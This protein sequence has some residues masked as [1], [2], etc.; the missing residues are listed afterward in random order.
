MSKRLKLNLEYI[1]NSYHSASSVNNYILK[2]P[3]LDFVNFSCSSK[4]YD[5]EN[6][7]KNDN[8]FLRFIMDAGLDFEKY[9][10]EELENIMEKNNEKIVK[11]TNNREEI[12]MCEKY[13]ET[14]K[15]IEDN[16]AVIYQGTLHGNE[17]FK[18]YGAPDLIVRSDI[19]KLFIDNFEV[20]EDK[21]VIIDIKYSTLKFNSAFN[22]MLN[23]GRTPAYKSQIMV[24]NKLLGIV[25]GKT[26]DKCYILGKGWKQPSSGLSSDS[27]SDQLGVINASDSDNYYYDKIHKAF[28]WLTKLNEHGHEWTYDPPSVPELYPNMCNKSG[29]HN[30]LKKK[31]AE[32][33]GEITLLWNV[34]VANREHAHEKGIYSITDPDLSAD[35]LGISKKTHKYK[36]VDSMLKF[37]Q[38]KLHSDD[39]VYPNI[40]K[41]NL[42]NWQM[43]PVIEFF[44][45]FETINIPYDDEDDNFGK[46]TIFM[47]GLGLNIR[48]GNL[49]NWKY[50]NMCVPDIKNN[51]DD[52]IFNQAYDIMKYSI[53]DINELLCEDIS[54]TD[55][56]VYHWGSIENTIIKNLYDKYSVKYNWEPLTLVDMY[57]IFT[58]EPIIIKDVYSYSLKTVIKGLM[59][60]DLIE[61]DA[62][63]NDM[64]N[65]L[66]AMYESYKIYKENEESEDVEK[67]LKKVGKY[68]E[69][70]VKALDK[71]IEY[72]RNK[73]IM[74]S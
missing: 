10:I 11:V 20:P 12:K 53:D 33:I 7:K 29:D 2:D 34:G 16:V 13:K 67:K 37:N 28:E 69:V 60:H 31:I 27:W 15:H 70:D 68:N 72:L 45:D 62:W 51:H 3:F 47:I 64:S 65:G 50:I 23:G 25:L 57:K 26:P 21:Y 56:N 63:E 52:V 19:I 6:K 36:V 17:N 55:V 9:I 14:L 39:E 5:Y 41:N 46:H 44:I 73:K 35:V 59:K 40:I 18:A 1:D 8:S 24:Y 48:I 71:I 66:D 42:E 54:I 58:S 32:E 61:F 4:S 22:G 49:V 38:G 30:G 74:T 43:K